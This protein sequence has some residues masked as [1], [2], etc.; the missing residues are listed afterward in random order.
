MLLEKMCIRGS[1]L[2]SSLC[3]LFYEERTANADKSGNHTIAVRLSMLGALKVKDP[4]EFRE[5]WRASTVHGLYDRYILCPGPQNWQWDPRWTLLAKEYAPGE[6][7]PLRP[8]STTVRVEPTAFSGLDDWART[9]PSRGRLSEIAKPVAIIAAGVN[10]DDEITPA[11][12]HAA[13]QFAQWQESVR[14]V[15]CPTEAQTPEEVVTGLIM[16]AFK[17]A[18]D[19]NP[20]E[21]VRFRSVMLEKNWCRKF[22]SSL[23]T[24][25]K[26]SLVSSGYLEEELGKDEHGNPIR[27]RHPRYRLNTEA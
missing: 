18:H 27:I 6:P 3:T 15:Y 22:G 10:N 5:L 14:S 4:D 11:C 20:V 26:N 2:A 21:W 8:L 17:A 9:G 12:A 23:V 7:V 1:T 19:R 13:L 24:R 16:D 25:V